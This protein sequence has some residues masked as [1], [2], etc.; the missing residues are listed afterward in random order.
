MKNCFS[1]KLNKCNKYLYQ[2]Y[3][4]KKIQIANIRMKEGVSL[5]IL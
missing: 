4:K 1:E 3:E 5:Q 2:T